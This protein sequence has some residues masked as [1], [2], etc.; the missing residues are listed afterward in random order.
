MYVLKT[1]FVSLA[2]KRVSN[3]ALKSHFNNSRF[4]DGLE[5]SRYNQGNQTQ[6][7]MQE[8]ESASLTSKKKKKSIQNRI[9]RRR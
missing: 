4:E 1:A 7:R 6:Q 2:T 8:Y 3:G 9:A 5:M